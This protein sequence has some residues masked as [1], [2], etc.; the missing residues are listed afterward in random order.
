MAA[1]LTASDGV[2]GA[3]CEYAVGDELM[4]LE[5]VANQLNDAEDCGWWWRGQ[6]FGSQYAWKHR[7]VT[8]LY[9]GGPTIRASEH[10]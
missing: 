6:N 1:D 7:P 5:Y 4:G 10:R 3:H 8:R 2:G 9:L